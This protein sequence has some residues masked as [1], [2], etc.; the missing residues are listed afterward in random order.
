MLP[1]HPACSLACLQAATEIE[2]DEEALR[3]IFRGALPAWVRARGLCPPR[4]RLACSPPTRS[5]LS[6]QLPAT[7]HTLTCIRTSAPLLQLTDPHATRQPDW[8]NATTR[9]L[10]PHIVAAA[11]QPAAAGQLQE[12]L[13]GS[14]F[15]RPRWLRHSRVEVGAQGAAALQ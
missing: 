3:R 7:H 10:W 14:H 6:A 5:W 12:L 1:S 13:N 8:L 4:R 2:W 9:Q 11:E 15:W